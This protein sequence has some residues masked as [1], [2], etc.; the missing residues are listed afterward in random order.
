MTPPGTSKGAAPEGTQV[1][2]LGS[3][4]VPSG[5]GLPRAPEEVGPCHLQD[6]APD[7]P[8]HAWES[9]AG[10]EEVEE[11]AGAGSPD[12]RRKDPRR[13][14]T[15]P[16]SPVPGRAAILGSSSYPDVAKRFAAPGQ[17]LSTSQGWKRVVSTAPDWPPSTYS[18]DS[19]TSLELGF[20]RIPPDL[21]PS[22]GLI[23]EVPAV[24][25]NTAAI[26]SKMQ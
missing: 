3:G 6:P 4:S 25:L 20:L 18:D 21:C 8:V 14:G 5:W 12:A 2:R 22:A 23:S 15:R 11:A 26:F 24:T 17:L 10:T 19:R 13:E 9:E 7:R 16:R 1:T